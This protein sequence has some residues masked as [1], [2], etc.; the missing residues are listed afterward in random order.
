MDLLTT[1][2][3]L[4]GADD[5]KAMLNPEARG[6]A[7]LFGT[8]H[9]AQSGPFSSAAAKKH[10]TAFAGQNAIDL[11]FGCC[12]VIAETASAAGFKLES[13]EGRDLPVSRKDAKPN[14][15]LAPQDLV[16][17]LKRPNPWQTWKSLIQEL[18]IDYILTG[19]FFVY[20]YGQLEDSTRPLA[21]Y[22]L[23]PDRVTVKTGEE[24]GRPGDLIGGYEYDVPG[25]DSDPAFYRP[26]E[27]IHLRAANPH[28]PYRGAGVV[29]G[30]PATFDLEL[31]LQRSKAAYFENGARLS[32]VLETD[33]TVADSLAS[34][35]KREFN[36]LFAGPESSGLTAVLQAGVKYR[37]IQSNAQESELTPLTEQ[38]QK[39]VLAMFKV[40][41]GKL[42][43]EPGP[44]PGEERREFANGMMRPLLDEIQTI[45]SERL[46]VPGW[47]IE[48][49][50]EYEYQMPIE[51]QIK[52]AGTYA[53]LP[54][55]K[56]IE[57]REKAGLEPL[58]DERDDIVLNLPG[59]NTNAS[60]IKDRNLPG[61]AGRPPDPANTATIPAGA[62]LPADAEAQA[63]RGA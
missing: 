2:R 23:P 6:S 19:D 5:G 24:T 58:G 28:S 43:M 59:D 12:K 14:E 31:A 32:G 37:T 48:F 8:G 25:N 20:E 17:L 56:I 34:K 9:S 35:L 63:R 33:R 1:A 61:E 55:I 16:E 11:V 36:S 29:A 41:K 30:G 15:R 53:Q 46:T 39:R 42:G 4:I 27:V 51:E 18:V 13:L 21:L 40:P 62:D 49:C 50:I 26:E 45:F 52:L 47:E 57:V 3:R 10:L 54:G 60:G 38:T 7:A 44:D 22:R